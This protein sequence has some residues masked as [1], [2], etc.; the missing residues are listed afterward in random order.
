MVR[1]LAKFKNTTIYNDRRKIIAKDSGS[2]LPIKKKIGE[3]HTR[4]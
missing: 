2:S 3:N 4:E 1:L